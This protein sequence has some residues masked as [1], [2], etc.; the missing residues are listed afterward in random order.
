M[1]VWLSTVG[2][3]L[4]TLSGDSRLWRTGLLADQLVRLGHSVTWWTSRVDHIHK[5]FFDLEGAALE[6]R[7]GLTLRFLD[8]RLY[9]RN[10]SVA[11]LVN[12]WQI[13]RDF[14]AKVGD[15]PRPDVIL[16]SFPT[17]ELSIEAVQFG[18]SLGVPV[19]LDVRDLWPDIFLQPAPGPIRPLVR[20]LLSPYFR[21]TR[22]AF[23]GA[24]AV[25]AVSEGY[26][27]WGLGRAGRARTSRDEVFPLAYS[28]APRTAQARIAGREGLRRF[29]IGEGSIACLFAG[30]LGR[31]YDL[32][33]VLEAART[34]AQ[35]GDS[36]FR[37][38]ICGDGER[39]T[40]W[41]ERAKGLPNVS[42]TGWLSQQDMHA[43]L[44]GADIGLAA[45]AKAA[46]QGVPNKVIEYLAAGLP[47]ISSLT[48]ETERLLGHHDCGSTYAAGDAAA[49]TRALRAL[50]PPAERER[51]GANARRKYEEAFRADAVYGRLARYLEALAAGPQS[52]P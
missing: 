19:V 26:L 47:V 5:R 17:I 9:T 42:F 24:S 3:P 33:P 51:V 40:E 16:C 4:P 11:R 2:E 6:V 31:T 48:G 44:A 45:Y 8:G 23:E 1:H 39:A 14:R 15:A 25:I 34:L 10:I 22:Q 30:T 36:P 32:G 29:G 13:G 41:Q 43:A 28:L 38:L 46:P 52:A 7:A 49:L 27:Q 50:A 21:A 35:D 18:R 20:L 37:F 12:H